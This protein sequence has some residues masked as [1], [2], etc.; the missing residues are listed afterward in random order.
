MAQDIIDLLNF[1]TL[2]VNHLPLPQNLHYA[3]AQGYTF[4]SIPDIY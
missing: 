2:N 3:C 4:L 1:D